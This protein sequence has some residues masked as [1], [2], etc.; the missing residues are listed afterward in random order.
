MKK[1][2]LLIILFPL[3][4]FSQTRDFIKVFEE[5]KNDS[6]RIDI[7]K[8]FYDQRDYFSPDSMKY[9]Y[10]LFKTISQKQND[11]IAEAVNMVQMGYYLYMSG[12]VPQGLQ[13]TTLALHM[14]EPTNNPRA[15]GMINFGLQYYTTDSSKRMSLI[16]KAIFFSTQADDKHFLTY[17][18][19]NIGDIYRSSKRADSAFYYYQLAYNMSLKTKTSSDI[20]FNLKNLGKTHYL[21]GNK[22]ISLE[23]LRSATEIETD[24][25]GAKISSYNAIATFFQEEKNIDSCVYYAKKSFDLAN[26]TPYLQ[27]IIES[28]LILKSTYTRLNSDSALKYSNIFYAARDSMYGRKKIEQIQALN[29]EEEIRQQ[30]IEEEK[31]KALEKRR[32]NLQYAATAIGLITFI[33]LFLALSR[34]IIVRE[35][36]IKFFGILGL[37]SVFEF[38]NLYIHPY[39]SN[40]TNDSPVL[41]LGI[42]IAIGAFLIPLHHRVEKWITK[43]M[44]EKNKKIRLTAAKKTIAKLEGEQELK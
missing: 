17:E 28:A 25:I 11:K 1:I 32:I 21:V 14:A 39:L 9:Y 19:R 3:K 37:L 31:Q 42:L 27:L 43:I 38:I 10:T 44:V 30:K 8:Q 41:M 29:F 22:K 7:L 6:V 5:S 20:I 26:S 4:T 36:F 34:S 23:Y 15:L 2:L 18:Y 24:N 13:L 33:I 12:E 35:K 40:L 16:K